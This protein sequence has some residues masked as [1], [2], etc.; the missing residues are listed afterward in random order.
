M[1]YSVQNLSKSFEIVEN[2]LPIL[3]VQNFNFD[4]ILILKNVQIV[5]LSIF[6]K[7]SFELHLVLDLQ[8]G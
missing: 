6:I 8:N 4:K 5:N 7:M 1:G 2:S 3:K